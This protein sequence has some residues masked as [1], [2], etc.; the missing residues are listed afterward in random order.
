MVL[1]DKSIRRILTHLFVLIVLFSITRVLFYIFN[2]SYFDEVSFREFGLGL[3]FDLSVISMLNIGLI[4]FQLLPISSKLYQRIIYIL[5]IGVNAIALAMQFIDMAYFPFTLRRS[6]L[7]LI[8]A[9]GMHQEMKTLWLSFLGQYW[10]LFLIFIGFVYL[11]IQ[12][13]KAVSYP[14]IRS[15]KFY[16]QHTIGSLIVLGLMFIAIR[17]GLQPKP[18]RQVDASDG[19]SST[20]V[21]LVLNTPFVVIK[22][23]GKKDALIPYSFYEKGNFDTPY[24]ETFIPEKDSAFTQKNV[25]ILILESFG[26]EN[27]GYYT[28]GESYTPFLDSLLTVSFSYTNSYANGKVSIA[29]LPSIIS[30][31]PAWY[32]TSYIHSKY[33]FNPTESFPQL[34]K[35]KGYQSS[36]FHGAFNGSQNFDRFAEIAGFDSYYGKNEYPNPDHDD[37]RWG[38]WDED[39]LQYFNAQLST[40]EQPFFSTLFT[41][42]SHNPYAV[43]DKYK[44]V[45]PK[46]TNI[47]HESIGY[48]DSSLRTFFNAARKTEWYANTLFVITADHTSQSFNSPDLIEKMKVPIFFFDPSNPSLKGESTMDIQHIDILP[49]VMSYLNYDQPFL[50]FGNKNNPNTSRAIEYLNNQYWIIEKENLYIFDTQINLIEAYNISLP[51]E[52]RNNIV[53]S[54]S[55]KDSI[56]QE[57]RWFIQEF[58]QRNIQNKMKESP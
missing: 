25:V 20:N 27:I 42:S 10:Y 11:L 44:G 24:S 12:F 28:K 26:K 1:K 54:I 48:T 21:P 4:F 22:S 57:F 2:K 14:E 32:N 47:I 39:F 33:V 53:A 35:E 8:T 3:R 16:I 7:S 5:F 23:I 17:G 30:G 51:Y 49:W 18:I 56:T 9:E 37:G 58:N 40:F 55:N 6:D 13:T 36:F 31:I 46:G 34:L 50:S 43:P 29:A 38:I 52:N 45:F 19:I 15:K 41:L